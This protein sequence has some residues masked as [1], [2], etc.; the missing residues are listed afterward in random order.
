M[1][2]GKLDQRVTIK[3]PVRTQDDSGQSVDGTPTTVD[4]RWASVKVLTGREKDF[5]ERLAAESTHQVEMREPV[6]V[7]QTDFL[8]WKTRRLEIEAVLP[9]PRK[10]YVMLACKETV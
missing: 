4:T 3:R 6:D 9:Q 2:A 7:R 1:H 8:V 5:A 10:G